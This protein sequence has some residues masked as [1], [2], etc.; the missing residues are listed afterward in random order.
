[1][2]AI[3]VT[4]II[5]ECDRRTDGRLMKYKPIMRLQFYFGTIVLKWQD[6][7][8]FLQIARIWG[9]MQI[10]RIWGFLQ[11]AGISGFMLFSFTDINI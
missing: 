4:E 1:M 7:V 5:I 9:F 10:T 2:I 8:V 6:F 11:I 3:L